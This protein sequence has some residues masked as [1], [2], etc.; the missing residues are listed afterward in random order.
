MS[1]LGCLRCELAIMGLALCEIALVVALTRSRII[2]ELRVAA[3]RAHWDETFSRADERL[4]CCEARL[5]EPVTASAGAPPVADD[6]EIAVWLESLRD[7]AGSL[8][9]S[10][11]PVEDGREGPRKN[12]SRETAEQDRT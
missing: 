11:T 3:L 9:R 6:E 8:R 1:E 10:E 7:L 4:S 5:A 2:T 12:V